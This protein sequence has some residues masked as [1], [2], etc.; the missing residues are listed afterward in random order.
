MDDRDEAVAYAEADFAE[1]NR[2]FV[3]RLMELAGNVERARAADFGCGPGDIPIRVARER[4]GWRVAAVDAAPAMLDIARR[5][6][7]EA[8]LDAAIDFVLADA[9]DSGLPDAAFDVVFSNSILH[10]I[11]ETDRLWAEVRRVAAPGALVFFRDLS[12]PEDE[13]AAR[14]IVETYAGGESALLREEFHRSLLSAWRIEEVREQ[15]AWAG[16]SGLTVRPASD[17]HFDVIGRAP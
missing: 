16:L 4:P 6:A 3:E 8:G 12:R 14:R 7:R 11:T 17:R 1:V 9:K 2:A 13:A 5:A 10:H 15:L